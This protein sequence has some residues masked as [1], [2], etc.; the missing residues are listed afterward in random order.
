MADRPGW[1]ETA[2]SADATEATATHAAQTNG[3]HVLKTLMASYD[4]TGGIGTLTIKDGSTI[5]GVIDVLGQGVVINFGDDGIGITKDALVSA[6]L[7]AGVSGI[8]G[9]I[10]M[11]GNTQ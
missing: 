2:T 9:H 7:S 4:Q 5:I 10:I 6:T 11:T 8:A 1:I 3:T